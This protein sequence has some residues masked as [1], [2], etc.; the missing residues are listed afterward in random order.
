VL[1]SGK[2]EAVDAA[3]W[4]A[5]LN[6]ALERRTS[7]FDEDTTGFRWIN[8]ESD[9]WP[10]LVLDRYGDTLVLKV[11]TAAWFPRLQEIA[12][13][14]TTRLSPERL[15]LRWSRN[16]GEFAGDYLQR[17]GGGGSKSEG[18]GPKEVRTSKSEVRIAVSERLYRRLPVGSRGGIRQSDIQARSADSAKLSERRLSV[19]LRGATRQSDVQVRTAYA[20]LC[21]DAPE[22]PVVFVESGLRFEADVLR[23]QKTGFFL[24][25]RENRRE[26]GRLAGRRR[27]LNA[28]S[29]SGAFS[30]YAAAGGASAV[31]DL[32][33]SGYALESSQRNFALNQSNPHLAAAAHDW[34]KA[35]VFQWLA[36]RQGRRFGLIVLDPPS[37]AK[38]EAE[39]AGA[40]RGYSKLAALALSCL[41]PDGILVA[42]SC[43]A[44]VTAE[45]FFAAIRAAATSS[46]R[47][48]TS[49]KTTGHAPDHPATFK[50]ARY[51]KAIYLRFDGKL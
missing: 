5:R 41:D 37:L 27:V 24:D 34:V 32:D 31:T 45:E 8:G 13:L 26:V 28:F 33:I 42:C 7:R 47:R 38:R 22:E 36:E 3:W 25:Q 10:G 20:M 17:A 44:H 11:Y 14:I 51:L 35:D 40:I 2:P 48:F 16:V 50:E 21:G 6:S 39:R 19:G 49:V 23:G 4:T 43:S 30:V 15:V 29:F 9:G 18:R 1:F 12:D 46:R